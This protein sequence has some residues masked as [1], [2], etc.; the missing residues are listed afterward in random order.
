VKQVLIIDDD[1]A[2]HLLLKRLMRSLN[3]TVV[4]TSRADEGLAIA[5]KQK[6]SLIVMDIYLPLINGWSAIEAIKGD[7]S[8]EFIPI[9]VVTAGGTRFD[10]QKALDLGC[11]AFFRKPFIL[12]QMIT[13][14]SHA[15]ELDISEILSGDRS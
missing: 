14:I 9:I 5:R 2:F 3:V 11:T 15:L 7:S 13:A 12:E 1:P 8:L 4:S 10:G 6:P